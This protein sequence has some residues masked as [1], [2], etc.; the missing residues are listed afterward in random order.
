MRLM[1]KFTIPVEK[2][3]QAAKDGTIGQAV[4]ALMEQTQAEAAYFMLDQGK[5]AGMIFFE[6]AD[7]AMLTEFNEPLFA[8]LNAAIEIVPVINRDDLRR[9]LNKLIS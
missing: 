9:G 6:V 7:P 3:N 1:L 4:D 2:G 8:K 5:R